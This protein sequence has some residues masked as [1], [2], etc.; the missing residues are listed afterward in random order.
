ML[1]GVGVQPGVAQAFFCC[2]SLPVHIN[3]TTVDEWK[4]LKGLHN[5]W[6]ARIFGFT[7]SF[8]RMCSHVFESTFLMFLNIA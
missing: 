1:I 3:T 4:F 8:L 6:I 5:P 2:S 7:R